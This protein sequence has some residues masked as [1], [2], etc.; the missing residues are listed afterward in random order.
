MNKQTSLLLA[1]VLIAVLTGAALGRI[2]WL[3]FWVI[4]LLIFAY[5]KLRKN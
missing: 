1:V 4:A 2:R 5:I 3:W